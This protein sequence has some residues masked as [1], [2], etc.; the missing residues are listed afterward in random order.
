MN[1]LTIKTEKTMTTKKLAEA[2]G[3]SVDTITNCVKRI[4][5]NKLQQ[6]KTT[7][8]TEEEVAC[9]SKEL[10][11]NSF[12]MKHLTSEVSSEVQNTTTDLE[13]MG[14]AIKAFQDLKK[15]YER[16]ENELKAIITEQKPKV[17]FYDAVTGSKDTTDMKE[18]A[19]VLNI[20]GYGRNKLFDFLRN[21]KVLDRSNIPY[22][23]FVDCGYFRVIESKYQTPEGETRINFK[24]VVFQK[25]LDYIRKLI[26]A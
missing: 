20:K 21:K 24:T 17:E 5:P 15:L 25:G 8:F 6:G 12:V 9:I 26:G 18:V 14:N 11:N 1:E 3:V 16:K 2:L 7:F 23:R 10:K 4:F 13:I 22:Q 19:K